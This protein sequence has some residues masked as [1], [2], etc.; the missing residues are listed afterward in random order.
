MLGQARLGQVLVQSLHTLMMW[1]TFGELSIVLLWLGAS[2]VEV[3][4][5]RWRCTH[6]RCYNT[7]D[8]LAVRNTTTDNI[9]IFVTG[10]EQNIIEEYLIILTVAE[11]FSDPKASWEERDRDGL[12]LSDQVP[13]SGQLRG[14]QDQLP[15]QIH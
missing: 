13:G 3:W 10:T 12:R 9:I 15:T 1:A 11:V 2:S 4:R 7:C 6:V 5:W 14:G 8:T